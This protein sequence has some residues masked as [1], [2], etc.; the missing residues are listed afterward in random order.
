MGPKGKDL[1]REY[2]GDDNAVAVDTHVRRWVC[3]EAKLYCP[4]RELTGRA[5]QEEY[6]HTR[7]VLREAADD[8]DIKPIVLQVAAWI[9]GVCRD[10]KYNPVFL[11]DG[12]TIMC[13]KGKM[14]KGFKPIDIYEEPD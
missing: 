10:R 8:C 11:G 12:H 7:D 2:L 14:G 1:M 5:Y 6:N 13:Q 3:E 4:T 9:N